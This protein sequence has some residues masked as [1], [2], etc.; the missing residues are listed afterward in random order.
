MRFRSI[1]VVASLAILLAL[2]GC[3]ASKSST[4]PPARMTADAVGHNCQMYVLDHGGPKAQVH[5]KGAD[6]PLWF[7][8]VVDAL[9][10]LRGP[11]QEAD[12]TAVY[13]SDMAKAA[14]WG[15]P[16]V[17]NW[18][19]AKDAFYVVSSRRLGGMETPEA[20]PFSTREAASA[21]VAESGGHVVRF[22][23]IPNDY[24]KQQAS[25]GDMDVRPAPISHGG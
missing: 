12:V 14:S 6:A 18:M 15:E 3:D 9:A 5:L 24:L 23:E 16:G 17:D 10:Y 13:V 19:R 20:I 1:P 22:D 8:E 7:A 11:E 25:M 4:P 21:F 2:A